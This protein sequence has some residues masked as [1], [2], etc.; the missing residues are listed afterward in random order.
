MAESHWSYSKDVWCLTTVYDDWLS[1]GIFTTLFD[2]WGSWQC[3]FKVIIPIQSQN[4]WLPTA[5]ACRPTIQVNLAR[6]AEIHD[7]QQSFMQWYLF[8]EE[9]HTQRDHTYQP[10]PCKHRLRA[11]IS[12][13]CMTIHVLTL[14]RAPLKY[15]QRSKES[16]DQRSYDPN[17]G[18]P[19]GSG[20]RSKIIFWTF[21]CRWKINNLPIK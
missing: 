17:W 12:L 8:M 14:D 3:N 19:L 18:K 10:G 15:Q 20:V 16:N 6:Q 1:L 4:G 13:Y 9:L 2:Y 21:K 7:T 5:K 11:V